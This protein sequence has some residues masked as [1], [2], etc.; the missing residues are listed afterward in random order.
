MSASHNDHCLIRRGPSG[1]P[2]RPMRTPFSMTRRFL[3]ADGPTLSGHWWFVIFLYVAAWGIWFGCAKVGV[4]AY[5][6]QARLEVDRAPHRV[7]VP[8]H[9]G[10]VTATHIELGR[11]V[12]AGEVLL[13]IED[14]V[15]RGIVDAELTRQHALKSEVETTREQASAQE[16]A[17]QELVKSKQASLLETKAL[18]AEAEAALRKAEAD[19]ARSERL[20]TRDLVPA[21]E[22]ESAGYQ[23]EE[24]RAA[25]DAL[26]ARLTRI[27]SDAAASL[28]RAEL[29]KSLGKLSHLEGEAS[30]AGTSV[31]VQTEEL[32]HHALRAPI[33][34]RIAEAMDIRT[35]SFVHPG[36]W[37]CTIVP[38]G[39]L[40]VVAFYPTSEA[41]GRV[42]VGQQARLRL[43]GFPWPAYGA[44]PATVSAI[45]EEPRDG[46]IRAELSVEAARIPPGIPRQHGLPGSLEIEIERATPLTL[47][48]RAVGTR[49]S[50]APA[51]EAAQALSRPG[52]QVGADTDGGTS[53]EAFRRSS[54]IDRNE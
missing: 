4:H 24:K 10:L 1:P 32:R 37:V 14:D 15:Q 23:L 9:S 39:A 18:L 43:H 22:I 16:A 35:G 26:R 42:R 38:E 25:A 21:Q 44:T 29:S 36:E 7:E 2:T 50:P 28:A 49:I 54:A 47:V 41:L 19:F 48:L 20:A 51:A 6:P 17:V 5:T 12:L 11:Q 31:K 13:E 53:I 45:A 3:I 46:M 30:I 34:G 40:R 52:D 8:H 27:Q 33:Q